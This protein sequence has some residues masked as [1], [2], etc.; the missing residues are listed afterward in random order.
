MNKN[1]TRIRYS[2]DFMLKYLYETLYEDYKIIGQEGIERI[3]KEIR[4][5]YK[6]RI[7]KKEFIKLCDAEV[8]AYI[9]SRFD[10]AK[11]VKEKY[12]I[13]RL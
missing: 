3:R 9:K 1:E 8:D 4:T 13:G 12:L 11:Y 10:A 7:S 6:Y 5:T 2:G